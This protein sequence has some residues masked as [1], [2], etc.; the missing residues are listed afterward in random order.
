LTGRR[1][2]C[3][4]STNL[5]E[6]AMSRDANDLLHGTLD[7]LVLKAVSWGPIHGYGISTWI[8]QRTRDEL[9]I[10]DSALYKA[11]HRLEDSGAIAAEWGVSENN[12]RARY[13]SLTARGRKRLR[14]ETATWKRFVV[15]VSGVLE[16][17]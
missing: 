11:L 14:D 9:E 12:R 7:L 4:F 10:V 2:A 1:N 5:V 6:E 13:Y 3:T 15:A 16:T 17:A 8:E